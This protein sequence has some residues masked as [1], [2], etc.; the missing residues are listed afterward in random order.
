M[1]TSLSSLNSNGYGLREERTYR[2]LEEAIELAQATG[3]HA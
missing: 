3:W 1:T 2:F